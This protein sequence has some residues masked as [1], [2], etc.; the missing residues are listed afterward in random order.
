[1]ETL[2]SLPIWILWGLGCLL[3]HTL[4]YL[5]SV[6]VLPNG[7]WTKLPSFTAHQVVAMPF[8]VYLTVLGF[9]EWF[10]GT[11]CADPVLHIN[12]NGL[13][14]SRIVIGSMLLWDI[15]TGFVTDGMGD[16]I[17]HFHHL[18]MLLVSGI[19]AGVFSSQPIGSCYAPFFFGVVELSSIPLAIVDI[20][21]PKQKAWHDYHLTSSPLKALNEISRIM[22]AL[23]YIL[24][25]AIYFPY[26]VVTQVLPE[27]YRATTDTD[28]PD[29]DAPAL[30][31]IM[32]FSLLFTGL[33]MYWGSLVIKQ[34]IK[35]LGGDGSDKTKKE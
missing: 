8:M 14:L 24:V 10:G 7:P 16:P 13:Y 20:F 9:Q 27:F 35:A 18:G 5:L 25:R 12:E 15:P 34:I 28:T 29:T 11:T 31:A 21:H 32:M 30:W 2:Q 23:L 22:F 3:L 6:Y 19:T 1:M 33:Q 26:V 17:M 4:S